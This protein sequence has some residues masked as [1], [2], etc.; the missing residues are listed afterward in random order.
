MPHYT[1]P[2]RDMQFVLHELLDVQSALRKLPEHADIDRETIDAV[3]E[4]GGRF[5]ADV[6]FPLNQSGDREGC[7]HHGDGVVTTPKGFKE[8][9]DQFVAA[10]WPSLGADPAACAVVEDS[11]YGI[12]A[13]RAAA[14]RVFAYAG[15][16]TPRDRLAGP[17]TVVFEDMRE[18]PRLLA[19]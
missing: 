2:L 6:I 13:A 10:G 14:M 5:C 18:L 9:Y 11:F 12:Q 7:T 19:A 16:L 17:D 3:L 1:P 8:A 15:G 4:E